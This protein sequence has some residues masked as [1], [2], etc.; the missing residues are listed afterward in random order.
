[1]DLGKDTSEPL[2]IRI[3]GASGWQGLSGRRTEDARYKPKQEIFTVS[4]GDEALVFAAAE[5]AAAGRADTVFSG[6]PVAIL[7]DA[8]LEA[9]RAFGPE[10]EER[11]VVP[12]LWFAAGRHYARVRTLADPAN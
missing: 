1:M 4:E 3:Y 10:G 6:R 2:L 11:A 12:M 8:A 5:I 7:W 9:P